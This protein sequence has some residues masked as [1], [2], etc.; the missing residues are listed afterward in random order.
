VEMM[1]RAGADVNI[2]NNAG[3]APLHH[4]CA[5][6]HRMMIRT[7][8]SAGA[9]I[10]TRDNEGKTPWEMVGPL[11]GQVKQQDIYGYV[12]NVARALNNPPRLHRAIPE[13]TTTEGTHYTFQIPHDTFVDDD[14]D[15]IGYTVDNLPQSWQFDKETRTISGLVSRHVVAQGVF[16]IRVLTQDEY[17]TAETTFTLHIQKK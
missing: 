2:T 8:M 15:H 4:A 12:Q 17:S 3:R 10:N 16:H 7:V 11:H 5:L 13:Q 1:L 6:I 14:G 9:D